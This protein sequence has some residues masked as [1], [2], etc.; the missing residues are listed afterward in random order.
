MVSATSLL[1]R[2]GMADVV[3]HGICE[4]TNAEDVQ[5]Y[6]QEQYDI[7]THE[8]DDEFGDDKKNEYMD[9]FVN[10]LENVTSNKELKYVNN[11][12]K[13]LMDPV[14]LNIL[15]ERSLL[16]YELFSG[17][18]KQVFD[19]EKLSQV[20]EEVNTSGNSTAMSLLKHYVELMK[21]GSVSDM[22]SRE[23]NLGS[24]SPSTKEADAHLEN[25]M[26]MDELIST[27]LSIAV[28]KNVSLPDADVEQMSTTEE[29]VK[30]FKECI[31]KVAGPDMGNLNSS[32][33]DIK[34][35]KRMSMI[36][37]GTAKGTETA[38]NDLKFAHK[39][40]TNRYKEEVSQHGQYV[41]DMTKKYSQCEEL[42]KQSN[43][44]LT[45]STNELLRTEM[46]NTELEKKIE[47]MTKELH[48][49]RAQNDLLKVDRLG[50]LPVSALMSPPNSATS[51]T[52]HFPER[53]V[54]GSSTNGDLPS[55]PLS[56]STYA[57]H[58]Q[59]SVGILRAEFRKLVEQMQQR[60][61]KEL[62]EANEER[63]RLESLFNERGSRS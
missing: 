9:G 44:E 22:T 6:L 34:K 12:G 30:W 50:L 41:S 13:P 31:Y 40:L 52:S 38:L 43:A 55:S 61:D 32:E 28:H 17:T 27:L 59:V 39:Y 7:S 16:D 20:L 5:A 62:E 58:S 49:L 11:E 47:T 18:E 48:E 1:E 24:P 36:R 3:E 54:S 45:R 60:H 8:D 25:Y 35:L 21:L 15:I 10:S 63:R 51:P 37:D 57:P 19:A 29:R 2:T 26:M 33:M 56:S 53:S 14:E 42:L 23:D 4:S 46:M